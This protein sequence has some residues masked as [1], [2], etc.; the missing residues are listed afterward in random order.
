MSK[1]SIIMPTHNRAS[2]VVNAIESV[3]AQSHENWELLI[4]ADCC[5]DNTSEV[6]APYLEDNRIRFFEH[7]QNLGG[8]GA[9]N[10]CFDQT[11][12]EFVAF[13]DDDDCWKQDKLKRQLL[14]FADHPDC[15]VAFSGFEIVKGN[16]V[17]RKVSLRP[18]VNFEQIQLTNDCGSFSFGMV[19]KTA[20][21]KYRINPELRACQDWDFW[22][23]ILQDGGKAYNTGT[24]EIVYNAHEGSRLSTAFRNQLEAYQKFVESH[25][26]VFEKSVMNFHLSM[27]QSK[28]LRI[29]GFSM[30][31][32]YRLTVLFFNSKM[33]YRF[34]TYL[35][36]VFNIRNIE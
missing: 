16:R 2:M 21:E 28:W 15:V 13:L 10:F 26:A 24:I 8:A 18:Q 20:I 4:S 27:I 36:L 19:R 11:E 17:I 23:K 6:I 7:K 25:K 12:G 3:L 29:D 1:V 35:N 34:K 32:F 22:F 14:L 30:S 31:R 33:R 5:T 9:R